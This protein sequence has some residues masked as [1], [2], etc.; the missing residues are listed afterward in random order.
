MISKCDSAAVECED[1]RH[2]QLED[3]VA[4][5]LWRHGLRRVSVLVDGQRV[6]LTG[7]VH[8]YYLKQIAQET[9]RRTCPD[10]R[11]FNDVDVV[12][13]VS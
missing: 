9:A 6:V 8:S 10:M 3:E 11:L 12:S 4:K 13:T 5:E 7:T 2:A 1:W